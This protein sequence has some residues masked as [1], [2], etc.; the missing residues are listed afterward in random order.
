MEEKKANGGRQP[1]AGGEAAAEGERAEVK[2]EEARE[3]ALA[4][5]EQ[6]PVDAGPAGS[7]AGAPP[8]GAPEDFKDRW[9]RAEAELQNFRRRAQREWEEAG[10]AAEERVMLEVILALDDL[11]RALGAARESGAPESW[12]AG[13]QLVANRLA[14]YLARR[15]V[16]A[17]DP[18]GEAFDPRFHEALLEVESGDAA[19]GHVVQAVLR[20]Y[21]R[22]DRA[23]RAA[24]VVVARRPA[25][26]EG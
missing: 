17:L 21:R 5:V 15:G 23:L 19:P 1:P 7:G 4:P 25:A 2:V 22:G 26:S 20:G 9:L 12:T 8:A 18:V 6:A 10:R 16:T 11:E 3:A 14:E 13:V 24:R